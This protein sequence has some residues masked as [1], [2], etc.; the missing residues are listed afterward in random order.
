MGIQDMPEL[1]FDEQWNSLQHIMKTRKHKLQLTSTKNM[2]IFRKN[3]LVS[4]HA[5]PQKHHGT[6]AELEPSVHGIFKI[7]EVMHKR[8]RVMNVI[9]GEERTLPTE[10][11]RPINLE[12]LVQMKFSLQNVYINS[13]FNRLM[14]QNKYLG[15]DERK[16]WRN[17][18]GDQKWTNLP[19]CLCPAETNHISF[20]PT[21]T[22]SGRFSQVDT[23]I[24]ED[25]A[26][27]TT[28]YRKS[29]DRVRDPGIENTAERSLS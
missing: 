9:T 3:Q 16:T 2:P 12:N 4:D 15:P 17:S 1:M 11:V 5:V 24:P 20:C 7:K 26:E 13:H 18:V 23:I 14:K 25:I 6:S 22:F 27:G 10:L 8:L 29:P 21:T 28:S 19:H